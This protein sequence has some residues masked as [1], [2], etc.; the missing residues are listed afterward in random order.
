MRARRPP[1]RRPRCRDVCG[2]R[3]ASLPVGRGLEREERAAPVGLELDPVG[4][5]LDHSDAEH[6]LPE[7]GQF[8]RIGR[9]HDDC[10]QPSH[11]L[12]HLRPPRGRRPVGS[13]H[14][15]TAGSSVSG[16]CRPTTPTPQRWPRGWPSCSPHRRGRPTTRTCSRRTRCSANRAS[17]RRARRWS[18]RPGRGHRRRRARRPRR[19]R[20]R[21]VPARQPLHHRRDGH[22]APVRAQGRAARRRRASASAWSRCDRALMDRDGLH[23]AQA[24][25]LGARRCTTPTS[26]GRWCS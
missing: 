7:L 20:H 26:S 13:P 14:D 16:P 10:P 6:R 18:R 9:I 17:T 23:R 8:G 19:P 24:A 21:G 12:S 5:G 3:S 4:R 15:R 22:G 2:S 25:G 1:C 11:R